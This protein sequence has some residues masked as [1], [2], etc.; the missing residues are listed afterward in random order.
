VR[1]QGA[2]VG[3]VYE[4]DGL[5]RRVRAVRGDLVQEYVYL[6]DVLVGE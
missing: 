3:W 5:G 6:G 4:Y 1:R 2:D